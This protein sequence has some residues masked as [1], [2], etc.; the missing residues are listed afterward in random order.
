MK[1]PPEYLQAVLAATEEMQVSLKEL[2][3]LKKES[4]GLKV[5]KINLIRAI[6]ALEDLCRETK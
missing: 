2:A 5:R 1:N 6:H 4:G 3:K